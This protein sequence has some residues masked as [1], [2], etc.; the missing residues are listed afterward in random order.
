MRRRT[1]HRIFMRALLAWLIMLTTAPVWAQ[2][3]MQG[4]SCLISAES[5]IEGDLVALCRTLRIDGVVQGNLLGAATTAVIHGSVEGSIYLVAGRLDVHGSIGRDLH[6]AGSAVHL[7]PAARMNDPRGSVYSISL[8]TTVDAM[9]IPG[10]ISALGYQLT[11][12][13][14]VGRDARFAGSALALSGRVGGNVDASVSGRE[15][16][17]VRFLLPLLIDVDALDP[18][19]YVPAGASIDGVLR[20]AAPDAAD[21]AAA[22]TTPPIFTRIASQPEIVVVDEADPARVLLAYLSQAARE[23][24]MLMGVGALTLMIL[25]HLVAEWVD[26]ERGRPAR[27]IGMGLVG[28]TLAIP[29]WVLAAVGGILLGVALSMIGLAVFGVSAAA[30]I[31]ALAIG[32]A[33]G[34]TFVSVFIARVI[35]CIA[36]GALI[37]RAFAPRLRDRRGIRMTVRVSSGA[38]WLNL[39][40]GAILLAAAVSLPLVGWLINLVAVC[41]GLGAIIGVWANRRRPPIIFDAAGTMRAADMPPIMDD[42][43]A[44]APGMD[45]LPQGFNWWNADE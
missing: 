4:D 41:A 27:A 37:G 36:L 12:A 44:L 19:L 39:L 17:N 26:Y 2:S 35:A 5:V 7:Y 38:L 21:I 1:R 34:F 24:A 13:G 32:G 45:N 28:A 23:L 11:L 33:S 42:P 25:P 20:Y 43:P 40:V 29:A 18:G 16:T 9:T 10:S 14:A 15:G 3:I 30:L 8:S 31:V 6:F 22:L